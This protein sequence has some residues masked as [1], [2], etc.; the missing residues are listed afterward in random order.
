MIQSMILPSGLEDDAV[1]KFDAL[2]AKGEILYDEAYWKRV[3]DGRITVC[4]N[5]TTKVGQIR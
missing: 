4:H 3:E 1:A 2:V 5:S